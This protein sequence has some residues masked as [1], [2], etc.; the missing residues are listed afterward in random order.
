MEQH[1]SKTL[2]KEEYILQ[3]KTAKKTRQPLERLFDD[4]AKTRKITYPNSELR[5]FVPGHDMDDWL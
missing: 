4:K 1:M 5:G 2:R 3:C